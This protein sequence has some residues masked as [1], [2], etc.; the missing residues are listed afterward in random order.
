MS[1]IEIENRKMDPKVMLSTLW[2]VVMINM[3]Y[4]DVLGLH[5]PG[6]LEEVAKTAGETPIPLLMLGGAILLELP[7]LM[8]ILSRVLK[9]RV[10]RWV[11]II[12][13]IITIVYV[14]GAGATY[15][16][17]FF[18]AGIEVACMLLVI[19]TALKWQLPVESR[20]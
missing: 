2:I 20:N 9:Y 11:N 18:I 15:P 3:L 13:A 12:V 17:Y 16:H 4:A 10:N 7:L 14:V 8:I 5:I 6:T 1:G 19:V